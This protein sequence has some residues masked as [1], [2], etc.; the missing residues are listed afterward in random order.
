MKEYLKKYAR[1]LVETKDRLEKEND[2][3][4][5]ENKKLTKQLTL[6]SVGCCEFTDCIKT[7]VSL[8]DETKVT[9]YVPNDFN[10]TQQLNYY[11]ELFKKVGWWTWSKVN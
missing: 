9:V 4:K 2:K 8:K 3:L 6:T 5:I 7:V 1:D 10:A 11:D